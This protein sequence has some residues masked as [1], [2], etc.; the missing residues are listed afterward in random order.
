MVL[1]LP[2]STSPPLLGRA[3]GGGADPRQRGIG[4]L[5]RGVAA[6]AGLREDQEIASGFRALEQAPAGSPG[7]SYFDFILANHFSFPGEKGGPPEAIAYHD[8]T[9]VLS[10]SGTDPGGELEV[11]GFY[12]G[13]RKEEDDPFSFIWFGLALFQLGIWAPPH[14]ARRAP[15]NRCA[16]WRRCS[17]AATAINTS[18][19]ELRARY[20]VPLR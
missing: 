7:R 2:A 5:A 11:L 17:G 12:A 9:H 8:M 4:W 13:C 16:C 19:D 18:L 1:I 14:P 6:L 20:H 10:G 15:S 3:E